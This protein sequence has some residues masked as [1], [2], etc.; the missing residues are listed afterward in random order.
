MFAQFL[1]LLPRYEFQR[2]VNK[3][4]G[5]YR[6][7]HFKCWNQMACMIFAHIRQEDSL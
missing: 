1:N 3:Y 5:D 6:T 4:N 7:K 2:I